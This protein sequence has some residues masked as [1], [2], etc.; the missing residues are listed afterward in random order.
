MGWVPGTHSGGLTTLW[1]FLPQQPRPSLGGHLLVWLSPRLVLTFRS[2]PQAKKPPVPFC[3]PGKTSCHCSYPSAARRACSSIDLELLA[4]RL[5]LL[6]WPVSS[7][8]DSGQEGQCSHSSADGRTEMC[9][10][11]GT[12]LVS[13]QYLAQMNE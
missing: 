9:H 11:R 13:G 5:G 6:V 12:W 1:W 4:L 10:F 7:G 2:V 8:H 3:S